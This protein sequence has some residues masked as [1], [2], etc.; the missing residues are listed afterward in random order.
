M[1]DEMIA[2]TTVHMDRKSPGLIIR[3]PKRIAQEIGWK[4]KQQ[5]VVE[6]DGSR[7]MVRVAQQ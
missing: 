1:E 2:V 4:D 6:T 7:L 3:L 5:V